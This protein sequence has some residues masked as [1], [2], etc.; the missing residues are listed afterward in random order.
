L[1]FADVREA[2]LDVLGDLVSGN[3]DTE[4]LA[5]LI[6]SGPPGEMPTI[7]TEARECCAS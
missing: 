3:L 4:R 1:R 7:A 2:R 5:A 6:E